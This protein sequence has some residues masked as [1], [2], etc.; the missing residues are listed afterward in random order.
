MDARFTLNL[1]LFYFSVFFWEYQKNLDRSSLPPQLSFDVWWNAKH[2]KECRWHGTCTVPNLLAW[3]QK[4]STSLV[5]VDDWLHFFLNVKTDNHTNIVCGR[6]WQNAY[7]LDLIASLN[8]LYQ[9]RQHSTP[10]CAV[11]QYHLSFRKNRCR[12]RCRLGLTKVVIIYKWRLINF[13]RSR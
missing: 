6:V 3:L 5:Q 10:I 2:A 11:V 9:H 1:K 8:S 12:H 13:S 7:C 4:L